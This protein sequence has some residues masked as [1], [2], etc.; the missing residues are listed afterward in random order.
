MRSL[1]SPIVLTVEGWEDGCRA[2]A[3]VRIGRR[4]AACGRPEPRPSAHAPARARAPDTDDRPAPPGAFTFDT[5]R[6]ALSA[7]CL[8]RPKDRRLPERDSCRAGLMVA[9]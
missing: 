3:R 8:R 9:A 6:F 1:A 4:R 5:P 2:R 7:I